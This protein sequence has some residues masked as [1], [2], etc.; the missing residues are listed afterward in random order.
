M[1]RVL[2]G[3]VIPSEA[4]HLRCCFCGIQAFLY[5]ALLKNVS[6]PVGVIRPD[7]CK[8][9]SLQLQPDREPVCVDLVVC[10]LLQSTIDLLHNA[11]LVLH[12]VSDLVRY[13]V[14]LGKVTW[15][16]ISVLRSR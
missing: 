8:T 2:P 6:S 5:V 9:I 16:T 12:L 3:P 10:L 15:C 1:S 7:A 4:G 13:D 14:C 11:D